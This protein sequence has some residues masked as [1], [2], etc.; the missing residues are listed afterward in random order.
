MT[1]KERVIAAIEKRE[2]D[3][4]PCSFSLHFEDDFAFGEEGIKSHL[5]FFEETDVD[6][7]KI[8]NENRVPNVDNILSPDDWS[9]IPTYSLE[10]DFMQSQIKMV[11]GIL[12]ACGTDVFTL[13]T[14]HGICASGI[15]PL[16]E[17]TGSY[18]NSRDLI[19]KHFRQNKKPML[20]AFQRITDGMCLLAR[21][22]IQLGVDG[23]Y[24]ASLG[25]DRKWFT[26]DEFKECIDFFDKQIIKAIRDEGGYIMLHMCNSD[27]EMTRYKDYDSLVDIVNW[28][29]YDTNFSL[30]EG[31]KLFPSCT[32]LGGLENRSGIIID[33][34]DE[35][36]S[37][38]VKNI[39]ANFGKTGFMIGADCTLPTELPY[40]RIRVATDSAHNKR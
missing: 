37:A 7:L 27:L 29:V 1:K 16:K 33:A 28:G 19:C 40:A 22:Y 32:I 21:K 30:E 24:L 6:I 12:S 18:E 13:G 8:M 38:E 23:V 36:L 11:E 10:D 2:V 25:A 3:V 26:D 4:I 15:H 17:T 39:I 14:I 31:R 5:E 9:K 34:T 35:E 20:E